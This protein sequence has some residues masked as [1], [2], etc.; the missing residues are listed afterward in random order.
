[1]GY[2][3]AGIEKAQKKREASEAAGVEPD[4]KPQRT[5]AVTP[6]RIEEERPRVLE[7]SL[8]QRASSGLQ[9]PAL[10]GKSGRNMRRRA[11][12]TGGF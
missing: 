8:E 6:R 12:S 11:R 3:R 2:D 10:S 9:Y 1:M 5:L 7:Q 4:G